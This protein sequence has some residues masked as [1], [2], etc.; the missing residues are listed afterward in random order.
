[1]KD[2]NGVEIYEGD[3]IRW[4]GGSGFYVY[5]IDKIWPISYFP[6]DY[7]RLISR[8]KEGKIERVFYEEGT[9]HWIELPGFYM[10]IGNKYENPEFLEE[11]K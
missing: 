7:S 8:S 3:F 2:M 10:V 5:L 11:V 9:E 4:M 1:L 6:S